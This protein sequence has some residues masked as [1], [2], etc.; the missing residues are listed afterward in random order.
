M[1]IYNFDNQVHAKCAKCAKWLKGLKEHNIPM[2]SNV[3][4][5]WVRKSILKRIATS[6]LFLVL[7]LQKRMVE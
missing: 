1:L 5:G 2:G 6:H 3:R 7:I 4:A